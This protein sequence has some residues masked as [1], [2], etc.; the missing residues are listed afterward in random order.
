MSVRRPAAD[1]PASRLQH[2]LEVGAALRVE[3]DPTGLGLGLKRKPSAEKKSEPK[4]EPNDKELAVAR[5]LDFFVQK[6]EAEKK[7]ASVERIEDEMQKTWENV[8]LKI[9]QANS[10]RGEKSH[11]VTPNYDE[12]VWFAESVTAGDASSGDDLDNIKRIG[13]KLWAELNTLPE[14]EGNVVL[15]RLIACNWWWYRYETDPKVQMPEEW[16]AA[17]TD[18]EKE[19]LVSELQQRDAATPYEAR[20]EELHAIAI[21]AFRG[22]YEAPQ[23][24]RMKPRPNACENTY[25]KCTHV[26]FTLADMMRTTKA[27]LLITKWGEKAM[28]KDKQ[29]TPPPEAYETAPGLLKLYL[30]K[31]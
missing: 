13:I 29:R 25:T 5:F 21:K 6:Q 20:L 9:K 8:Q 14:V 23:G 16:A 22:Q 17:K 19:A 2:V 10:D 11:R 3:P 31:G 4:P 7:M 1:A 26:E 18:E 27:R 30:I 28:H 12:A 24:F 15:S